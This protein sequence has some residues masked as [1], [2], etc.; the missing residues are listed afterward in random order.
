[1]CRRIPVLV[2]WKS[3][4]VLLFLLLISLLLHVLIALLPVQ[5]LNVQICSPGIQGG[6]SLSHR[7]PLK[8]SDLRGFAG[9]GTL[10]RTSQS[11]GK[12]RASMSAPALDGTWQRGPTGQNASKLAALFQHPLYNI[13]R[14]PLSPDDQLFSVNSAERFTAKSSDSDGWWVSQEQEYVL[15]DGE[16]PSDTYPNWL[17]FFIGINR[18]ELYAQNS[19]VVASLLQELA[20]L[21]IVRVIQKLGGTQLKLTMTLQNYGKALFKPLK[22]VDDAKRGG[23]LDGRRMYYCFSGFTYKLNKGSELVRRS[24]MWAV[25]QEAFRQLM[26]LLPYRQTRDEETSP[27]LFYF[28][29]FERHNAE[30]AAFHLDRILGFRRIPPVSGRH[31][32]VVE[33]IKEL[34]TDDRLERTFFISP[35]NN[36]CFYGSCSYYCNMEHPLCGK[37]KL[38][39]GSMA[40]YL[41]DVTLAKRLSWRNPWKRSYHKSK[42]AKWEM[43]A[44][45]CDKIKKTPPYNAGTRLIDLMDMVILDF[46]MGNM[47]RHHYE[48]FQKFG[49]D[50]FL[51]HLDNGR[52][53]GRHSYDELSILAPLQQC[54]RIRRSTFLRLQLLATEPYRLSD[55]VRESLWSDQL[56]P[57]LIEP[58]L[59][60]L[61]RRLLTVLE[62]TRHCIKQQGQLSVVVNDMGVWSA[63]Q[64]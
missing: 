4:A 29:D 35:D 50:S 23:L 1:M 30:I 24:G 27:D 22:F 26:S 17:K 44:R 40:A 13:P 56:A 20:T 58:H 31:V 36:V 49:N 8:G 10:S 59:S 32:N 46:L 63:S 39:E 55:V 34:T 7:L 12:A 15:P 6:H 33:D 43:N 5:E 18:R 41:P 64:Q 2:S 61:D 57:I 53:F 37:P 16:S 14:P 60:A 11:P 28:S 52:G 54:C 62:T 47:D 48:T 42:R 3:K 21:R 9:T 38:M 19:S 25:I 45:Y 51:L